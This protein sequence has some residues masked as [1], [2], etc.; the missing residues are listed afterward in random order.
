MGLGTEATAGARGVLLWPWAPPWVLV[1]GEGGR[2]QRR[3]GRS[4][5]DLGLQHQAAH[6]KLAVPQQRQGL[7]G[8]EVTEKRF[9]GEK[10]RSSARILVARP[11]DDHT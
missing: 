11:C 8:M 10:E 5:L 3:R 6:T 2:G 7:Q 4:A 9:R 1:G